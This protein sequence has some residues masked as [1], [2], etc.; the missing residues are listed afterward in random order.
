VIA[1][2]VLVR[3][4]GSE[5]GVDTAAR[6]LALAAVHIVYL[7]VC[8]AIAVAASAVHRSSRAA[9][10]TLISLWIALW[11]VLPRTL[12][13]VA[14]LLYPIP[15][16]ASFQAAVERRVRELGDSHDPN[17]PRFQ[18][19][20]AR[21]LARFGVSRVEDLP[22]NYNGVVMLEGE[23]LTTDAYRDHLRQLLDV[24][25]R[26]SA[27]VESCAFISPF[28]AMR[29]VSM[30]VSGVDVRHA[31]EFERQAEDFRFQM[32]QHLNQ[33]HTEQVAQARDRYSGGAEGAAPTRQRIDR[34]HF[35]EIDA[36]SFRQP[37]WRWAVAQEPL[38]ILALVFWTMLALIGVLLSSRRSV[39]V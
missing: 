32:I 7:I 9:L 12:P 39:G 15:S 13:V 31:V 36:F 18:E 14:N 16:R 24:Y 37:S 4:A 35:Q 22:V 6:A 27:L 26:Q 11:I 28:V 20:K 38:G 10:F 30:A 23:K 19:L 29:T 34:S 33:L 17:D 5:I 25:E 1:A 8:A 21:Y 3:A 2:A